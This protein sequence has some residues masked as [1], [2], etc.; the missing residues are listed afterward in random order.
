MIQAHGNHS[1]ITLE[2]PTEELRYRSIFQLAPH[3]GLVL[4]AK[5]GT[6]LEVN[7]ECCTLL[8]YSR[9]AR[10]YRDGLTRSPTPASGSVM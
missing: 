4:D 10:Y 7:R 9:G 3:A 2:F 6:V 8:G 5:A 1:P